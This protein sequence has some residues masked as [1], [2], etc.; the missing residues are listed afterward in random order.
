M[1][2][3]K[4]S[5]NSNNHFIPKVAFRNKNHPYFRHQLSIDNKSLLCIPTIFRA[6]IISFNLHRNECMLKRIKMGINTKL[7]LLKLHFSIFT[8]VLDLKTIIISTQSKSSLFS[9]FCVEPKQ[10]N[11]LSS[12]ITNSTISN[13]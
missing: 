10:I 3:K 11:Q 8:T 7:L 9:K 1:L 4:S 2:L 13:N 6:E 12:N 5:P